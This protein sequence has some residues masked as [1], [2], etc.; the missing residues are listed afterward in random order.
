MPI[1]T[2]DCKVWRVENCDVIEKVYLNFVKKLLGV[3][4]NTNTEMR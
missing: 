2:F 4:P 3:K 1:L